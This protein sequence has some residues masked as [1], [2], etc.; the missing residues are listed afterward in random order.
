M[1]RLVLAGA[2]ALSMIA[3]FDAARPDTHTTA[4]SVRLTDVALS[5][6][7]SGPFGG[8]AADADDDWAQQQEQLALQQ[9]QQS[10]QQAEQQNEA[11]QQ[12]FEQDMQQAQLTEQQANNP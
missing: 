1:R 5:P 8:F 2:A 3:V 12:Q 6:P 9:M 7:A 10:M 11:A 4:A